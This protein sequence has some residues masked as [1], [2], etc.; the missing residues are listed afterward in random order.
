MALDSDF[1]SGMTAH[2]FLAE[3]TGSSEQRLHLG[4]SGPGVFEREIVLYMRTISSHNEPLFSQK[5]RL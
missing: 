5:E 3:I 2:L 1:P 4:G